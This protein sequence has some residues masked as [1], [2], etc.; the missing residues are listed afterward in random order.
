M[1]ARSTSCPII[2]TRITTWPT[3]CWSRIDRARQPTIFAP[4]RLLTTAARLGSTTTSV[5]RLRSRAASRRPHAE[6]RARPL[7]LEP[8]S[9]TAHRNLGNVLASRGDLDE[10]LAHL[11]RAFEID[12]RD[13]EAGYDLGTLL[14]QGGQVDDAVSVFRAV[15]RERP[16]YAEAHNN[17]GIALGSQGRLPEAIAQ[18]EQALRLKPGFADAQRNLEMAR[19]TVRLPPSR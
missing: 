15:V 11:Q 17:L 3:R 2:P 16:D 6:F 13:A 10:A 4:S 9:A 8:G 19:R 5:W 18:F 7:Q 1:S 14:L 12:P